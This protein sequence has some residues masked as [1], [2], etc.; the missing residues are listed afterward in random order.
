M[1]LQLKGNTNPKSQFHLPSDVASVLLASGIVEAPPPPAPSAAKPVEWRVVTPAPPYD[2]M[3]PVIKFSC[4]NCNQSG[5]VES[6]QGT[7]HQTSRFRHCGRVEVCPDL[8]AEKYVAAFQ[9]YQQQF[10]K[11]RNVR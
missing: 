3:A 10:L 4:P 5:H 11:I 9:V 8:V 1:L 7:A 2:Q 6:K